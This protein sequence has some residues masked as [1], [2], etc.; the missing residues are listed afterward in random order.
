MIFME[1][2]LDGVGLATTHSVPIGTHDVKCES[3]A[4]SLEYSAPSGAHGDTSDSPGR[5]D[6]SHEHW[7]CSSSRAHSAWKDSVSSL[8]ATRIRAMPVPRRRLVAR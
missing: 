2:I 1:R 8:R 7:R 3:R 5:S 6:Q 4:V